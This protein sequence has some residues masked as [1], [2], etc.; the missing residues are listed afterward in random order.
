MRALLA[1]HHYPHGW[2]L[3]SYDVTRQVVDGAFDVRE[4]GVMPQQAGDTIAAAV[5]VERGSV[6]LSSTAWFS[7]RS[8]A[9]ICAVDFLLKSG[10]AS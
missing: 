8:I 10:H 6:C 4:E 9:I 1:W 3:L 7:F 5:C 2:R